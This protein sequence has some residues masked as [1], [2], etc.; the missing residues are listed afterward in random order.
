M[1]GKTRTHTGFRMPA[2]VERKVNALMG[3]GEFTT[4]SDV[5]ITALRFYFDNKNLNIEKEIERFFLS[6]KGE[7]YIKTLI[8]K[9]LKTK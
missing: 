1:A 2:D 3:S 8:E 4:R 5:I 7:I 6:E 9:T